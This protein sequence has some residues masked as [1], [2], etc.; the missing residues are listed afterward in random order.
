MQPTKIVW[1]IFVGDHPGI[2]PVSFQCKIVIPQRGQF[3]SQGHNMSNFG[4]GP[5]DDFFS[6]MKALG[7]VVSDKKIF[8]KCICKPIFDTV[9]YLCKQSELFE[10]I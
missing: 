6:N 10:Q 9:T 8:E 4:R 1:I 5:L 2:I 7:L 3:W